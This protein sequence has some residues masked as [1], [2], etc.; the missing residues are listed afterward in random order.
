MISA[1]G[2]LINRVR[3][4]KIFFVTDINQSVIAALAVRINDALRSD[5]SANNCLQSRCAAIGDNLGIN[6][7]VTLK[8]PKDNRFT[9]C[10][11]TALSAHSLCSEVTF[12]NLNRAA[13]RRR[14]FRDFRQ[15]D[16]EFS[17]KFG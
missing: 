12:V 17:S 5:S 9:A 14:A 1:D 15:R 11:A 7:T 10:S 16:D 2:K 3:H 4:A 6:R 8:N 13:K